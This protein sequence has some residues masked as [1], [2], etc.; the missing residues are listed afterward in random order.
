MKTTG[1]KSARALFPKPPGQVVSSGPCYG[2]TLGRWSCTSCKQTCTV[3]RRKKKKSSIW[4]L[5]TIPVVKG[6]EPNRQLREVKM[7]L[8]ETA[9]QHVAAAWSAG[10]VAVRPCW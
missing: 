2:N 7:L 6:R 4:V 10:R 5:K 8:C 9:G 3:F 1:Q